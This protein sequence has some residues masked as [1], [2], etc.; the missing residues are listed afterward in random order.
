M[1]GRHSKLPCLPRL[2]DDVSEWTPS[3]ELH[4]D[5]EFIVDQV[6]VEHV[7]DVTVMKVSHYH[8]LSWNNLYYQIEIIFI[9]ILDW[10]FFS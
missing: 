8:H 10:L 5:P 3:H 4:N 7:D 6:A 2:D 1:D 9:I